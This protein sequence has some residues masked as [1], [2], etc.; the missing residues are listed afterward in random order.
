MKIESL[1]YFEDEDGFV[2]KRV[3]ENE[4]TVYMDCLNEPR[5]LVAAKYYKRAK[6]FKILGNHNVEIC[7]PDEKMK[8]K[9]HFEEFLKKDVIQK[10]NT[11]ISVLNVYKQAVET[12]Y[13]GI[14]LPQDH[15]QKFLP[16]LRRIRDY[17]K[18][19]V[20]KPKKSKRDAINS[21]DAA[22]SPMATMSSNTT[23]ASNNENVRFF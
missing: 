1:K 17:Q 22:T 13:K 15:R 7:P 5:C 16:V 12:R 10:E 21:C 18:T 4:K 6:Q 14:W 20:G 8:M 19:N 9:I 11:S 2:Y 3:N 23:V